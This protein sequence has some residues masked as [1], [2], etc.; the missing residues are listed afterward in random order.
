MGLRVGAVY[1]YT[2]QLVHTLVWGASMTF[3]YV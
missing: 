1:V 2:K 3:L